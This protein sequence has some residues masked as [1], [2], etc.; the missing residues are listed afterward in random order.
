M[1][2]CLEVAINIINRSA[3][4]VQAQK[5]LS[6]CLPFPGNGVINQKTFACI[7]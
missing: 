3:E 4:I 2:A 1:H 5:S 6:P 7:P